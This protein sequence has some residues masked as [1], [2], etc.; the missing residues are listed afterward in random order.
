MSTFAEEITAAE[1]FYQSKQYKENLDRNV[2]N[3]ER[4]FPHILIQDYDCD[5]QGNE[6]NWYQ[7]EGDYF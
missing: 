4:C 6:N 1:I 7:E 2:I 3:I 5:A